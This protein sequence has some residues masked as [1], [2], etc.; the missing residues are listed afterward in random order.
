MKHEGPAGFHAEA[1]LGPVKVAD[2]AGAKA[3][4]VRRIP[5]LFMVIVVAPTVLAS[6]YYLLIA[7]P[8]YESEAQFVV[9]QKSESTSSGGMGDMA[10]GGILQSMGL[11]GGSDSSRAQEVLKYMT[12]RDAVAE[13]E[14]SHHLRALLARPG[15]DFISRFPRPFEGDTVEDLYKGFQRFVT[16]GLDMQSGI[17]SLKVKAYRPEDAHAIADGLLSDGEALINRLNE[18]S[19]ADSVGQ[20]TRGVEDAEDAA[21]KAQAALTVFRN[22]EQLVNPDL[23]S[24]ANLQLMS[25]LQAQ[26]ANL[27]AQRAGLAASAAQSPQ[28]PVLDRNITAYQAQ[29]DAENARTAGRA[30]SL[31]PKVG[32]Y[33][34]LVVNQE[35][36][37]KGLEASFASLETARLEA[38]RKQLY[39]ERVISPNVADKAEQPKRL[40]MI[41]TVFVGALVAYAAVALT[42]AGLREHRQQ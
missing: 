15:S 5:P 33:E 40:T 6:I 1:R 24:E 7:S 42:V 9:R 39:L 2:R 17:S 10:G 23:N 20:A 41:L 11:S 38:A 16:V 4:W 36:A 30:D 12:S 18:Q 31:A 25:T 28:L 19:L 3:P 8:M 37:A 13:L 14:R 29:I 34:R 32:E 26:L 22:R 27:K 21:A 35:I